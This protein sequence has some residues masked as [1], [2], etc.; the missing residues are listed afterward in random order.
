MNSASNC[1]LCQQ[2][3]KIREHLAFENYPCAQ[4]YGIAV[5]AAVWAMQLTCYVAT[6]LPLWAGAGRM[7][8]L[9]YDYCCDIAL[10]SS[11]G[12]LIALTL[13]AVICLGQRHWSFHGRSIRLILKAALLGKRVHLK[14]VGP[15]GREMSF[16]VR[17]LYGKSNPTHSEKL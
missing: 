9:A 1:I 10:N 17:K 7:N 12:I 11:F 14:R 16:T 15:K 8:S 3:R 13:P 5:Y 2:Y 4:N 6:R